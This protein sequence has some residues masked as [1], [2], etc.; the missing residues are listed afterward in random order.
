MAIQDSPCG[1]API[2][3]AAL[4]QRAQACPLG[5]VLAL[6]CVAAMTGCDRN[7]DPLSDDDRPLPVGTRARGEGP[8]PDTKAESATTVRSTPN[9]GKK[10]AVDGK[11]MHV[12]PD[13]SPKDGAGGA[14]TGAS[15]VTRKGAY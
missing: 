14:Q 8:N 6:V 4:S 7:A 13:G 11:A 15:E 2:R 9:D 3:R 12:T 5:M 10:P 1:T